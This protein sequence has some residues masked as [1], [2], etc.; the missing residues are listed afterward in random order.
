MIKWAITSLLL[1]ASIFYALGYNLFT[2]TLVDDTILHDLSRVTNK[3][4][5]P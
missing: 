2:S 4:Q 3:E 5:L 1:S